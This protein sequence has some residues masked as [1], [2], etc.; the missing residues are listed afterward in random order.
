LNRLPGFASAIA[1]PRRVFY[2][3]WLAVISALVLVTT[4]VPLFNAMSVWAVAL[5]TQF[6]WNRTQLGLALTFTRAE[7]GLMG[8][9]E[10]FLSDRLGTKLMVFIGLLIFCA[11]FLLFS[12]V[13]NLWMFYLAFVVMSL[14]HGLGGWV[15]VMTLLNHWF[16]RH[17]GMAMGMA[18]MGTGAGSLVVVPA[19]AWAIDPDHERL[20]WRLTAM[21]VAGV[22]LAAAF[23]LPRLIR[24]RPQDYGLRPDGDPPDPAPATPRGLRP[25]STAPVDAGYAEPGFTTRQALRTRAFWFISFGHGFGAMVILAIMSH[26]AL[27]MKDDGYGLQTAAW[28]VTVYTGVQMV[29]QLVGGYIGD[30]IPKNVALFIFTTIQGAAVILLTVSSSL[31]AF[32]AFAVVFGIGFGGRTPLTTAIRGEYF[33]RASFGKILGISTVPMNILLL[34]ASPMAGYMRDQLGDYDLAFRTLAV[35]TFVGAILFLL[36]KRPRLP[37]TATQARMV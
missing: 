34:I 29:F 17:R 23:T 36:A 13:R 31:V 19:I 18:M 26:L 35:L 1:R 15:P 7:G 21:I 3:W 28:V 37:A 10:G 25:D 14:G 8:P 30:R 32:Y 22:A 33:G 11:G 6:G 5:E 9:I 24:N 27:A 16:T 20:G 12:Q 2:G 4:I